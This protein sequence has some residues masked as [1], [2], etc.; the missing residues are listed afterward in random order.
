M[1]N[2]G[3]VCEHHAMICALNIARDRAPTFADLLGGVIDERFQV[4]ILRT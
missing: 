1:P 3:D 2:A 4:L